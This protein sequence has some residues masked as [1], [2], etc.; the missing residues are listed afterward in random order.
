M[1]VIVFSV[2]EALRLLARWRRDRLLLYWLGHLRAIRYY[3]TFSK[4]QQNTATMHVAAYFY[5]HR[6]QP[7]SPEVA[8]RRA[9]SAKRHSR[10]MLTRAMMLILLMRQVFT[11]EYRRIHGARRSARNT[12]RAVRAIYISP[13]VDYSLTPVKNAEEQ[14]SRA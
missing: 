14:S 8:K 1:K 7:P 11:Y 6:A 5:P 12:S 3:S 4:C 10:L 13:E 2:D 9:Y